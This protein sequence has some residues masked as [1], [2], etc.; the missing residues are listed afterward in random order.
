MKMKTKTKQTILAVLA[1]LTAALM[2][3]GVLMAAGVLKT[4]AVEPNASAAIF[5]GALTAALLIVRW[6]LGKSRKAT[7]E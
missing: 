3:L 5:Y 6:R 4:A 1:A 7:T 2:V